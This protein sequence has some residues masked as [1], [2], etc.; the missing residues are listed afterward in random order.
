MKRIFAF[1]LIVLLFVAIAPAFAQEVTET[2]AATAEFTPAPTQDVTAEPT[3]EVTPVPEP[4]EPPP[5]PPSTD[6]SLLI[7][8]IGAAAL[9]FT[10]GLFVVLRTA[11]IQLGKSA[12]AP[13]WEV[14][15]TTGMSLYDQLMKLIKRTPNTTDDFLGEQFGNLLREYIDEVDRLRAEVHTLKVQ[16]A[17][18][19]P[20]AQ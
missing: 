13:G 8:W 3:A 10:I 19:T 5:A 11:F 7:P 12:P 9:A 14:A 16:A 4:E 20:P 18:N 17:Q 6:W 2:P 15:K 1:L